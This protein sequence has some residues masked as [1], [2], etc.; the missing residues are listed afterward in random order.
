MLNSLTYLDTF[1]EQKNTHKQTKC[2]IRSPYVSCPSAANQ[3]L[4]P[5]TNT[6]SLDSKW[7]ELYLHSQDYP[8]DTCT[9][10]KKTVAKEMLCKISVCKLLWCNKLPVLSSNSQLFCQFTHLTV[11]CCM[12]RKSLCIHP[13]TELSTW[14][15]ILLS[16]LRFRVYGCGGRWFSVA[17]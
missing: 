9:G 7:H 11:R 15:S 10:Q 13:P 5:R 4:Y 12:R 14:S 6:H 16:I 17:S 3:Q 1:A 8:L 2:Y